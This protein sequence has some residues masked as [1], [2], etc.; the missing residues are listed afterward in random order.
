MV[1]LD[2]AKAFLS[3]DYPDHDDTVLTLLNGEVRRAEVITG[4]NYTDQSKSNYEQ[5]SANIHT[6]V[7]NGVAS[8]FA[9]RDDFGTDGT[10]TESINASLYAYRQEAT[11]PMF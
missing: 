6:A 9:H 10:N 8:S 3:I 5:M 7:L 1:T 11:N 4:R 2:E